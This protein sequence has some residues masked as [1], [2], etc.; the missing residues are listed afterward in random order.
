[1]FCHLCKQAATEK[2]L[3]ASKCVDEAFT[4]RGFSNWKDATASFARHEQSKCHKEATHA[5][6]TVPSCYKDCAEMLSSQHAKE[7]ADSRHMLL[8][9]LS[10]VRFLARQGLPLRGSGQGDDSNFIQL[11]K[12]RGTD[13]VRLAEWI[14]RKSS[15]YTT[16]DMQNEMLMVMSLRI[17][18]EIA[19]AIRKA[20]FFTVMVD[21]TTDCSNKEQVVIVIRWV[22]EDLIVHESFIG[23]YSVPAINADML[24]TIIKDSLVRMNLSMN[25][26]RG[27]CYDGASNMAGAKKGVAKQIMDI[28]R[29][30]LFTHCYGH[31]LNLACSD[32]V[33]G[34]RVLKSALETTREI[35]K[36]IKFSPRREAIFQEVKKDVPTEIETPG[37]RLLCPTRWTVRGDSLDSVCENY[38]ILLDTFERSLEIV[39]DT[40][41]KSRIIGVLSQMKLFQYYFGV[42][43]GQLIFGHCDN[44]SRTLQHKDLSA[45]E[46]QPVAALTITTLQSIRTDEMFDLFW[47]KVQ[48]ECEKLDVEEA[49]LPRARKAPKRYEI[50]QGDSSYPDSPKALYRITY[51]EGLDLVV[52]AVKERFEQ[53]G[54]LM[55]KNLQ[56]ILLKCVHGQ[57]YKS[58]LQTVTEFY[59][60]DFDS[61][62]LAIQLQLLATHFET[63]KDQGK[64]TFRE[65]VEYLQSL[66]VAQRIFYSQV[67]ILVSLVLVMPATNATSERSFSCLR[68]VKSYLRSTM[69]QLRLNSTM[70]LHVHKDLT[71]ELNLIEVANDFVANK[72]EHRSKV[73]GLFQQK[74]FQT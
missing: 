65:T 69:I 8:K 38:S 14:Q 53:P 43:L 62:Q 11:L 23:L 6:V 33:K 10:N 18:R 27:Q 28:E 51:F 72:Q 21:E 1:M 36:L 39:S 24:T 58:E 71:D 56:E 67:I 37:I 55:Y 54:Y 30:A 50:G 52:N 61:T 48:M 47:E 68:R 35:T 4:S 7:K 49:K 3:M 20:L 26:I 74:D 60:N 57:D 15:K 63:M 34:C 73:F 2:K 25:K 59:G 40:E 16:A 41:T 22:D 42:K 9:I 70:L 17:L 44:L 32:A 31:T 5:I 46:G 12:L 29:R 13:D 45:A 66:S 19:S 64:I